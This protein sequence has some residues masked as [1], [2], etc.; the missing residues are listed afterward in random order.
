[1]CLSLYK[2]TVSYSFCMD[3]VFNWSYHFVLF[4]KRTVY[5]WTKAQVLN[6][7]LQCQPTSWIKH[8]Q[9]FY[10]VNASEFISRLARS[11]IGGSLSPQHKSD[12]IWIG[13]HIS[14]RL[15][16]SQHWQKKKKK[17][18]FMKLHWP[19]ALVCC[20]RRKTNYFDCAAF[21]SGSPWVNQSGAALLL[22]HFQFNRKRRILRIKGRE[23]DEKTRARLT[24]EPDEQMNSHSWCD[25]REKPPVNAWPHRDGPPR[26][27]LEY[28]ERGK[29]K[30]KKKELVRTQTDESLWQ[31]R[32]KLTSVALKFTA[33]VWKGIRPV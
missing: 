13:K 15:H 1:M 21:H 5:T 18:R 28:E 4:C 11:E 22:F 9:H 31:R 20:T 29:K 12:C 26:N 10:M 30:K 33:D 7:L 19:V 25:F 14:L 23:G 8:Y 6:T 32:A 24:L 3:K 27:W 2:Y 16:Q 17:E